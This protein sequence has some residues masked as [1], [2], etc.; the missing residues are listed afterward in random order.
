MKLNEN[1]IVHCEGGETLL[2]PTAEVPFNGV[3]R[4]NKTFGAILE[5]LSSEVTQDELIFAM[6][7]RY[8]ADDGVIE[9][10]VAATLGR[11]RE[12]GAI[13]E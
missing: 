10:D 2:V 9:N 8:D 6:K 13:D 3:V 4:G 11:L 5:I 12:I 1:F 7:D